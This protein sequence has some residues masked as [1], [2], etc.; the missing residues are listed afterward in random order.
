MNNAIELEPVQRLCKITELLSYAKEIRDK[1]GN[2]PIPYDVYS[3]LNEERR[4]IR[5][6]LATEKNDNG[7]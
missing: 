4:N 2:T 6:Q 1:T 3:A 5:E 7:E